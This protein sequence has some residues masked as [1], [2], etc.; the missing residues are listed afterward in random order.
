MSKHMTTDHAALAPCSACGRDNPASHKFCG[1]CGARLENETAPSDSAVADR[2]AHEST[3]ENLGRGTNEERRAASPESRIVPQ[4]FET[5]ITNPDELS[6]FRSFRPSDSSDEDDWEAE[7]WR[8]YRV[9]VGALLT[10]ALIGVAYLVWRTSQSTSR[11]SRAVPQAPPVVSKEAAAPATAPTHPPE[12]RQPERNVP[13]AKASDTRRQTQPESGEPRGNREKLADI[14]PT[15][16]PSSG[17]I[18]ELAMARRYLNG[19]NG[20]GRDSAEAVEWLWKSIAKHNSEATML[21]ADLYLKGDGVSK[22]C[23][24]AR[25]LLD[26]AAR[27]GVPAAGQQ[28]RN[29]QAFG[30]Q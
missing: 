21:L 25:V 1:A 19:A 23:D 28:L 9:Y 8:R 16:S 22:N 27:K 26:S 13:A 10:I 14:A 30:C 20:Q 29:L 18:E 17:G 4:A 12:T 3:T 24:Q 7:P 11:N 15:A 6:L 5:S 2:D